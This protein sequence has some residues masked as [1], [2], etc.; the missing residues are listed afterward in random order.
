M[1]SYEALTKC[2][3]FDSVRDPKKES[4]LKQLHTLKE[5]PAS[6]FK[7]QPK[8]SYEIPMPSK[9]LIELDIDSIDAF[10]Y[11]NADNAKYTVE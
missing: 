8:S 10:D 9:P 11:E 4:Y 6:K 1:S 2:K 5:K 3:C 7:V